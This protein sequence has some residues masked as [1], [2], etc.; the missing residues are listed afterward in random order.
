MPADPPASTVPSSEDTAPV[1]LTRAG[2]AQLQDDIDQL[3]DGRRPALVQQIQRATLF[4]D[5]A[6]GAGI[7][8]AARYDLDVLDKQ[9]A[10]L[11]DLLKRVRIVEPSPGSTS[12]QVGSQVTVR[13]QNQSEE[14]FTLTEP[15]EADPGRGRVSKESPVGQALLGKSDGASLSVGSG[16]DALSLSVVAVENDK[17]A[18]QTTLDAPTPQ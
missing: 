8:A 12:V 6:T 16:D 4:M 15:L 18:T 5:S 7:A 13:Y 9:L 11:D 2:L 3:H 1:L 17:E 10:R 14:T